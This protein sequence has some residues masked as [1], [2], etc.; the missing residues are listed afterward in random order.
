MTWEMV[1]MLGDSVHR[2]VTEHEHRWEADGL[3]AI[4]NAAAKL[5]KSGPRYT[6][7]VR[8]APLKPWESTA[9]SEAYPESNR[10]EEYW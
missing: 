9:D 5:S 3:C 4:R 8:L 7:Q 6:Y 2:V 1:E 10:T